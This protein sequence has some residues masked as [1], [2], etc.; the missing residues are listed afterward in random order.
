MNI[1]NTTIYPDELSFGN[2][3]IE[4]KSFFIDFY[5]DWRN[6]YL[7]IDKFSDDKV[8]TKELAN[9]IIEDGRLLC[10]KPND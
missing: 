7:T 2:L 1:K 10:H 5:L 6:N 4:N 9:L 3:A 8:M